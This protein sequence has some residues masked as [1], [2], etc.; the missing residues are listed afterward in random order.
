[1]LFDS[2]TYV[3]L[4][5]RSTFLISHQSLRFKYFGVGKCGCRQYIKY[6][7]LMGSLDL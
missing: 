2:F 6:V 7:A 3:K 4:T 1:M 5:E